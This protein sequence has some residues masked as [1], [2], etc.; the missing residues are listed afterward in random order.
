MDPSRSLFVLSQHLVALPMA[1]G[2]LA[3]FVRL[4]S[5]VRVLLL[6]LK[7]PVCRVAFV[8]DPDTDSVRTPRVCVGFCERANQSVLTSVGLDL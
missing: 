1:V 8:A 3:Y 6:Y 5:M 2:F 7:H 4:E